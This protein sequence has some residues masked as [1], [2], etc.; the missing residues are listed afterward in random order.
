MSIIFKLILVSLKKFLFLINELSLRNST[1]KNKIS[2]Y[3]KILFNNAENYLE[4]NVKTYSVLRMF[5]NKRL[6]YLNLIILS[7]R[8]I[9]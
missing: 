9:Y 8:D 6:H 3:I 4:R 2:D 5:H 7:R 1:K